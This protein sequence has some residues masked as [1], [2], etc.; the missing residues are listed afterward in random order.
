MHKVKNKAAFLD[1]DGVINLDLGYVYKI[2]DFYWVR[3]IKKV[4]KYLKKKNFLIIVITNQ[5]GIARGMYL[6][7]DVKILHNYINKQLLKIDCRIDA[8]YYCPHHPQG[9]IKKYKK[10]CNCR[11][12]EN[13][14]IKK[15]IKEWSIDIKKS[16]MIGD[17][18]TDLLAAKK[19]NLKFIYIKKNKFY[20]KIKE[21]I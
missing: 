8:F 15:A 6:N 16:F 19:S 14:M 10:K 7:K 1:R 5:S 2:T 4:I 11:K 18:K 20:K 13:G 12:P 17:Q 3:G 21:L 9:T